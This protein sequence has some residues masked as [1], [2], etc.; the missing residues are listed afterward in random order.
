M[1]LVLLTMLSLAIIAARVVSAPSHGK[2]TTSSSSLKL[3]KPK[4]SQP[5][6]AA[7]D[8]QTAYFN[9]ALPPGY[10]QQSSGRATPGLLYQQT[11]INRST[12]GSLIIAIAISSLGGGLSENTGYNLRQQNPTRYK[13]T[14]QN[15]HG[16]LVVIVNDAQFAAVTAFWVHRDKLATISVSSGLQ[17]PATDDNAEEIKALQPLLAAW[18]WQ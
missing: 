15:V 13:I 6:S 12:T 17:N 11:V 10:R 1:S 2:T 8:V 9:L 7:S 5:D 4:S 14:N 18:Q 16:E 3:A